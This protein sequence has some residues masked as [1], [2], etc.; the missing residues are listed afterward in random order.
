MIIDVDLT[1]AVPAVALVEPEDC[2]RFH[3]AVR[4]GDGPALAAALADGVGRLL[5]SGDAM[6]DTVAVRRMAGGRVP[7]GWDGDFAAMLQYAE[8]KG[9][10]DETG[11]SIQAHVE[12]G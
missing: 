4:G 7:E 3:V 8:S 5:P 9:W 11:G 12:W 6:I 2:K 10:L 1:G